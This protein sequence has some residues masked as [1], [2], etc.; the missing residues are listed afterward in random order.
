[1]KMPS[2][3]ALGLLGV[4]AALLA[5]IDVGN[6]GTLPDPTFVDSFPPVAP[7]QLTD[8]DIT[9]ISTSVSYPDDSAVYPD[10]PHADAVN[11]NCVACH[12]A[13]MALNQPPLSAKQWAGEV[14]KMR[15]VYKAPISEQDVP[16][17]VAYLTAMS[18]GPAVGPSDAKVVP[19]QTTADSSLGGSK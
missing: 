10:G 14:A 4:G 2:F 11:A 15:D 5:L 13:S 19:A 3:A 16:A 17:I 8:R 12:S 6:P 1:M 7:Y 18:A 9:L